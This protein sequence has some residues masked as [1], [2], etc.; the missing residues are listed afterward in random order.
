[1]DLKPGDLVRIT[2]ITG[3]DPEWGF[4]TELTWRILSATGGFILEPVIPRRLP[5]GSSRLTLSDS[6]RTRN[7]I[8]SV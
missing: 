2:D 1:M 6:A 5:Y 8:I 3:W 7:R 4:A